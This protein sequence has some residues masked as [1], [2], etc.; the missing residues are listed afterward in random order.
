LGSARRVY[1]DH[2]LRHAEAQ[3]PGDPA[4]TLP[5]WGD[6]GELPSTSGS[7]RQAFDARVARGE[8][9]GGDAGQAAALE[10]LQA[11]E[12][13]LAARAE[14]GVPPDKGVYLHGGPG[15]GKTML[16]D[17]FFQQCEPASAL[18]TGRHEGDAAPQGLGTS[19]WLQWLG[20]DAQLE[21][22]PTFTR[23]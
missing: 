3:R 16:M 11:L 4:D 9:R 22:E 21:F 7:V 2:A 17:L 6:A 10:A 8:L 13:R 14:R 12:R 18:P 19:L 20:S 23:A 15:R 1:T 5:S